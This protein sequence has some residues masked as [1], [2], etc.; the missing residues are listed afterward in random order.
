MTYTCHFESL[1]IDS[2]HPLLNEWLNLIL[3]SPFIKYASITRWS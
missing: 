2:N 3:S 1:M